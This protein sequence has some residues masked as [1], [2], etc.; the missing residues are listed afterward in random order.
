[1]KPKE[2]SVDSNNLMGKKVIQTTL[3]T[4]NQSLR[5]EKKRALPTETQIQ[6][7]IVVKLNLNLS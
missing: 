1:M 2:F 4:T 6:R 3:E 5:R 7:T